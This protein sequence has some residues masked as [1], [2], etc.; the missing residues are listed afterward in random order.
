MKSIA[1]ALTLALATAPTLLFAQ[2]WSGEGEM[3]FVSSKSEDTSSDTL[4]L[5]ARLNRETERW[6]H[7]AKAEANYAESE[8]DGVKSK[9]AERIYSSWKTDRKLGEKHYIYGLINYET[10]D[11]VD[12][13]YRINESVGYG[14][15]LLP[16]PRHTLDTEIG[17]GARQ[18][19]IAGERDDEGVVRL[20]ADYRFQ[21]NE[22]ARFSEELTVEHGSEATITRSITG[23]ST[24]IQGNLASKISYT[25]QR[26]DSDSETQDESIFAVTLVY[27]F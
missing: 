23:L 16:G 25:H 9:T 14:I 8:V 18:T 19:K 27:S 5:K 13:D 3:G 22:G 1:G 6:R 2:D 17:V 21:I 20:A 4:T 7:T 10:D 26:V 24:K 15:R 12:L 11:I